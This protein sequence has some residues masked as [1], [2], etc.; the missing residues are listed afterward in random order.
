VG[1][2]GRSAYVPAHQAGWMIS[3]QLLRVR[4]PKDGP[5]HPR[6][7]AQVYR[8]RSFLARVERYA[9]GSTRPSLNTSLLEALDFLVPPRA[10]QDVFAAHVAPLD[11]RVWKALDEQRTFEALRDTLLPRLLSGALRV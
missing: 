9:L 10:V 8:Q 7:L 5:L 1:V 6:Y 4:L 11:A 2:V 3:G